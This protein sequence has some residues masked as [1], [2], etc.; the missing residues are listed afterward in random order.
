MLW[1]GKAN[2]CGIELAGARCDRFLVIRLSGCLPLLPVPCSMQYRKHRRGREREAEMCLNRR[3]TRCNCVQPP[4]VQLCKRGNHS[5]CC[6][7]DTPPSPLC[8]LSVRQLLSEA[9]SLFS[10]YIHN[11]TFSFILLSH[12]CPVWI[13][14]LNSMRRAH[15]NIA[16]VIVL[17]AFS[18]GYNTVHWW[19]SKQT[20]EVFDFTAP[21]KPEYGDQLKWR[22]S[23]FPLLCSFC[24]SRG[25]RL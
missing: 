6:E 23:H 19:S 15:E 24:V 4:A 12:F 8:V 14:P 21:E 11:V 3:R 2:L 25:F 20:F 13:P 7:P 17:N 5:S 1:R 10:I 22:G 16:P 9:F 18:P